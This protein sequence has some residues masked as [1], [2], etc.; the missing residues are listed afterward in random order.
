MLK[1][2]KQGDTLTLTLKVPYDLTGCSVRCVIGGYE[3]SPV[4]SSVIEGKIDIDEIINLNPG[5]YPGDVQI[6]FIDGTVQSTETFKLEVV[7]KICS[8]G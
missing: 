8:I 2:V 7:E 4:I 3:L 6:E 5:V 1:S